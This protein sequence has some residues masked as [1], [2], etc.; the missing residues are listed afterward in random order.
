MIRKIHPG[1]WLSLVVITLY[2]TGSLMSQVNLSGGTTVVAKLQDG[3]G[4]NLTSTSSALDINIKSGSIGNA[5]FAATQSGNW[6]SR[7]QDGSG[8]AIT[9]TSSA[10]DVNLKSG[11]ISNTAF[12]LNAGTALIGYVMQI[13]TGC[14][15]STIVTHDTV[16][17]ATGAGTT[18]S[19][20]TGCVVSCYVNNITNAAVTMRLATKDATPIIW[21]GGNGDFSLPA[22]SNIGCGTNGGLDIAGITFTSGITAIAGTASALNLHLVTRE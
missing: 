4:N 17:I 19:S 5:S 6:S 21:V 16:G 3:S 14:G 22:N 9:S 2:V 13:P 7:T 15:G 18:V 8:N 10:L 20:V 12:A 11:S 1:V